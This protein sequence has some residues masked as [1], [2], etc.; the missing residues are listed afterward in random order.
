MGGVVISSGQ[1]KETAWI[2]PEGNILDVEASQTGLRVNGIKEKNDSGYKPTKE[3]I[4]RVINLPKEAVPIPEGLTVENAAVLADKTPVA[5]VPE[6]NL[7]GL[8]G[9]SFQESPAITITEQIDR[10]KKHLADLELKK[11]EEI[12]RMKETLA[13][14]EA[15]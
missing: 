4:E 5:H 11:K 1:K 9:D 7:T 2:D 14:L 12:Q 15:E 6:G 8:F 10:A 13:L 3:E